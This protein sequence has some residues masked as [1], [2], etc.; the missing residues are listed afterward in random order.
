MAFKMKSGNSPL[1]KKMGS[2][3]EEK[4]PLYMKEDSPLPFWG[5]IKDAAKSM[6]NFALGGGVIGAGVRALK[7]KNGEGEEED[8]DCETNSGEALGTSSGEENTMIGRAKEK[9]KTLFGGEH[10][11]KIKEDESKT[12]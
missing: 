12:E 4:G 8:C 7:G 2:T 3:P 6:G 1:F 9:A 10:W 5:K 11:K